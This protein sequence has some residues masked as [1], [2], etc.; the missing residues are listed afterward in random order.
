MRRPAGYRSDIGLADVQAAYA[1]SEADI[2]ELIMGEQIHI[3][4]MLSSQ[5]LA[6]SAGIDAGMV[7]VDLCCCTGA[8][9]RYLVRY[10]DVAR[11]TGVDAT[12]LMLERGR[13]RTAHEGLADRISFLRADACATGLPERSVDFVWGE[14][15]WCYVADKD[16]LIAE[17][18]RLARSGGVIAFTDWLEGPVPLS[19]R[20]AERFLQFM[21]FPGVLDLAGYR[22]LL[23]RHGCQVEVARDTGRFARYMNLYRDMITMQL[24]YDALR[25]IGFDQ[26]RMSALEADRRFMQELGRANKVIQGMFVARRL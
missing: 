3:G 13:E 18:V 4:G 6:E 16:A 25:V 24:T 21:T 23:E 11:M 14:D 10:R 12:E 2:A 22:G 15:A 9:M 8:G 5:E 1:T 26:E 20:E 7:G 17:A 19:R